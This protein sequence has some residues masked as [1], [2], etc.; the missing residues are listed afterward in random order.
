MSYLGLWTC[1]W[2]MLYLQEQVEKSITP[3]N[4]HYSYRYYKWFTENVYHRERKSVFLL[5]SINQFQE[6]EI[7]EVKRMR[8][9]KW[10]PFSNQ[11]QIWKVNMTNEEFRYCVYNQYKCGG[12][13]KNNQERCYE[14]LNKRQKPQPTS[15][16]YSTNKHYYKIK[17]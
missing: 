2:R 10:F 1:F 6:N 12:G 3:T 5:T 14:I 7:I 13:F 8:K 15:V 4:K 9:G 17:W 16:R 11:S